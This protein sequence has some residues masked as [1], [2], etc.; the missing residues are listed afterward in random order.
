VI[1]Q[2]LLNLLKYL[3]LTHPALNNE[4]CASIKAYSTI[5]NE[6]KS[7]RINRGYK[8]LGIHKCAGA[9]AS[10]RA[11]VSSQIFQCNAMGYR[12]VLK[13]Y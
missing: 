11:M 4:A 7:G 10:A 2:T 5:L 6:H 3:D 9:G 12:A 8:R 13:L 1:R